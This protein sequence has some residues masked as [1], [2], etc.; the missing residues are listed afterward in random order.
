MADP[1]TQSVL[2]VNV[3]SATEQVWEGEAVS[4]VA[5]T[6]EGEIGI[7]P[8][9]TPVLASLAVGEVRVKTAAGE[10]FTAQAEDGF[11][12]VANDVVTVL[13][14]EASLAQE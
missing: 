2:R 13:A 7:L 5:R 4:V 10:T 14:G 6:T 1:K 8:G 9:H 12:S 11:L 3:T